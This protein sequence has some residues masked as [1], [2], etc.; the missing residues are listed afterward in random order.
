MEN[1]LLCTYNANGEECWTQT[2]STKL[3]D[4]WKLIERVFS[5]YIE[6]FVF[7]GETEYND[8]NEIIKQVKHLNPKTK[9]KTFRQ[10]ELFS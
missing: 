5:E 9:P 6:Y 1:T 3:D 2:H 8:R 10:L 7:Y 4:V